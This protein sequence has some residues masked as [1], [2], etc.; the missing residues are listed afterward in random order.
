MTTANWKSTS[1]HYSRDPFPEIAPSLLNSADILRYAREGCLVHPFS[2]DPEFHNPATY[3]LSFLGTLH[4]WE[5]EEDSRYPKV[6]PIEKGR[7][8]ELKANSISYLETKEEFRLPQYIAAR[9]NLHIRHVHRG[10]LLGRVHTMRSYSPSDSVALGGK[11]SCLP[12]TPTGVPD[13]TQGRQDAFSPKA[14]SFSNGCRQDLGSCC[15]LIKVV[16][17]RPER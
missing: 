15:R 17:R 9:F 7:P 16:F 5:Q 4:S 10:I 14:A 6:T 3:T 1:P 2:Y 8:V 12:R 11:A 13:G